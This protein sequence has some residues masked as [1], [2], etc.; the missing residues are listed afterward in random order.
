[1]MNDSNKL[2][3]S[4]SFVKELKAGKEKAF[5]L[6]FRSRYE[7]LCRFAWSFVSDY[8]VA[9]DIVQ[10]LFSTIWRKKEAID[11]KQSIDSYLF[12]SV[13]NA[14]Y[15]YLKN[16]KQNVSV[17]A[18]ANQMV[19]PELEVFN[20]HPGL[21]KLWNAV[22]ALPLQCK[23]VF[24]LVVLEELKYQ[25]VAEKLDVSVNTV[26]TQMKIAYKI[27]RSRFSKDDVVLL[28]LLLK[29]PFVLRQKDTRTNEK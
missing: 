29:R 2:I 19:E 4:G 7:P 22:E 5:D 11:E 17:D 23:V 24:K 28:L 12:V 26:K 8:S 27:L 15:T 1:M 10:E 3:G 21:Q 25:E 9:E 13:R 16:S 6:L 18:L 14:C 20:Q